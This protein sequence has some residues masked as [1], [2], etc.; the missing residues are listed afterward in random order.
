VTENTANLDYSYESGGL[1]EGMSDIL[2]EA[3]DTFQ[4]CVGW[5]I[6]EDAYTPNSPGDA[7]RYM[8]DPTLDGKSFDYYPD[9]LNSAFGPANC[10]SPNG[11]NDNCG[12]HRSSGIAN[13]AFNLISMGGAHP[14][15]KTQVVVPEIGIDIAR[16]VFYRALT[17][18]MTSNTGFSGAREATVQAAQSLYPCADLRPGIVDAVKAGWDAVGVPEVS[19]NLWALSPPGPG[20]QSP[21]VFLPDTIELFNNTGFESGPVV[22]FGTS[23]VVTNT[24]NQPNWSGSWKAWLGGDGITRTETLKQR[25]HIPAIATSATLTFRLHI[26]TAENGGFDDTLKVIK[27]SGCGF[28]EPPPVTLATWSNL[29]AGPGFV[30]KTVD[31]TPYIGHSILLSFTSSENASLQ[32]SFVLDAMSVAVK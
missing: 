14:Q 28:I 15:G 22:W 24:V 23:G 27:T 6:G 26:N 11:G 31:L 3:V 4:G 19:N 32:T 13:L 2:G 12:V 25:V 7:L 20:N 17:A 18:Y 9:Y 10:P 8:Y 29:N 21:C 30:L 16:K 5:K 1:N